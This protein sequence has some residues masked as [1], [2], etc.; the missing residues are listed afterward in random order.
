VAPRNARGAYQPT[1]VG[2]DTPGSRQRGSPGEIHPIAEADENE[3]HDPRHIDPLVIPQ[4]ELG[5]N[6][7]SLVDPFLTPVTTPTTATAPAAVALFRDA[8]ARTAANPSPTRE[9]THQGHDPEVQDWFS[10]LE[11][12]DALLA[13]RMH[14]QGGPSSTV[15]PV[16]LLPGPKHGRTGRISPTRRISVRSKAASL[17]GTHDDDGRTA[18][19]ISESNRSTLSV[20]VNLADASASRSA[21]TRSRAAASP[22]PTHGLSANLAEARPNTSGGASS[23]SG[24]T[25]STAKSSFPAL[26]AEGPALLLGGRD[27]DSDKTSGCSSQGSRRTRNRSNTAGTIPPGDLEEDESTVTP[28]SPSKSKPRA[29]GLWGN[30]RRV[31]SAGGGSLPGSGARSGS[32]VQRNSVAGAEFGDL[33]PGGGGGGGADYES[34]LSGISALAGGRLQR[35]RQQGREAWL[36]GD[37]NAAGSAG[38]AVRSFQDEKRGLYGG[39]E[40]SGSHARESFDVDDDEDWDIE[41]AVE[42]R[43]VQVMFTVP[44][45]RLRVVNADAESLRRGSGHT[46]TPTEEKTGQQHVEGVERGRE[47]IAV[48]EGDD[49]E[50]PGDRMESHLELRGGDNSPG[51]L[52]PVGDGAVHGTDLRPAHARGAEDEGGQLLGPG[53]EER[54]HLFDDDEETALGTDLGHKASYQDDEPDTFPSQPRESFH[55]EPDQH[56]QGTKRGVHDTSL[57]QAEGS[58]DDDHGIAEESGR[59]AVAA[60]PLDGLAEDL[61]LERPRTRVLEMVDNIEGRSRSGSESPE[62]SPLRRRT[63]TFGPT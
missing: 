56:V 9:G 46:A 39:G 43:L 58:R 23:S 1:P 6:R 38:A 52:Q 24:N 10:D 54:S 16:V 63:G 37:D 62:A 42:Q 29:S 4:N 44:K 3:E 14:T 49:G 55:L 31:F 28:G 48:G 21:S 17:V 45:E 33:M 57:L 61:R 34:P 2:Y 35:R 22:S 41:R 40:A 26:Q 59:K 36:T 47:G 20:S 11:V 50:V 15:P 32:P 5:N 27:R 30:L 18:S 53:D 25:F 19:N 7:S 12:A 8:A 51:I 13:A 60:S